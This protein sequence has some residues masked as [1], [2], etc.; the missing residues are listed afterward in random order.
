MNQIWGIRIYKYS[1]IILYICIMCM[2]IPIIGPLRFA[3]VKDVSPVV[4]TTGIV[5]EF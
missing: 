5:V 3:V 4:C 2:Y 1:I